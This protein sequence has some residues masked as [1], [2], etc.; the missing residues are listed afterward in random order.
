LTGVFLALHF[1]RFQELAEKQQEGK[2]LS[3]A[4]TSFLLAA[5]LLL[6][7]ATDGLSQQF[8][9]GI[10]G[11]VSDANGVVPGV[12]VTVINEA[13]TVPRETVSNA[14]GEYNFPALPPATYSIR[15]T[16]PGYKTF[17]R[18]GIRIA[19]QQFVT[20]DLTLEVGAVEESI[21][22]TADS[23]LIETSNASQGGVLDRRALEDL[24]S[25]GRNAFMIGVTVP[26]VLHV[27]EPRFNRQQDQMVASQL[28]LGGGG[29]QANNYTLDGVPISDMRGFPVLNPTIEAIEDVKVQVHTFDAEMGRTGGGVFNTTAKSGAN[30][31]HGT[32]FYQYR[33]TWG[34]ELE[35]F[36]KQ[37]GETKQTS[38]LA[39]SFYH[40]YGG[41]VG[42]PIV[43]NRTF[44]WAASEGYRDQVIQGLSRTWPSARQRSGDFS[45]T[46]L[47]GA[48]VR[49]FNPY[50]RDGVANAKCPATGTG[51]LATGGEFLNAVIPQSHPAANPVAFKMASY[52]PAPLSA[53]ENSLANVNKTINLPDFA[54]MFTIKGE[55]KFTN[56]SSLSGVFIY[57]QTKEHG[58]GA[59]PDDISFM[60]QAANWLIRHPKVFV[61]NN[62]NVLSDTMVASFRYGFTVF[63][64]GRNCRG[65]SV[66]QGCFANGIASLGFN[67]S[68]VNALDATAENL[69]PSV[70]FQNFSA[71]GQNLNTAPIEWKS[72]VTLNAALSKLI[73]T[74]TV[75]VGGDYRRMQLT[76]TLL[77]NTAGSFT[78]QNLFSAG[79]GRVGGY[80]FASFLIGAPT[81]GS[82]D[83]NRGGGVYSIKYGGAYVQ[84]D[85]RL[86]HKFTLNYG[87]RFEHESGLRERDDNITVGFDPNATSPE[88]QAIE[89][90]IRRN[91][92]TGPA[93]KGGVMFAGVNGANDYQGD[94]PGVKISPR[95][96]STW[97][98][99]PNTVVRG[100]YGLFFAPW[101]YT[102]QS[103]GTIGFVRTT[104]MAQSAPESA[105]P[106]VTLDNPFPSGLIRPTGSALGILTGVGGNIDFI[107]QNKGAPRVHQ[108]AVDMQRQ[109]PGEVALSIG[110]MGSTGHDI[111]YGGFTNTG[112]EINQ[113][114]PAT[115]PKDAAGRWDAAALRR[116]VPNPFFGV[117]GTG[118]L[119]ASPTILAGQLLRPFPQFNNITKFQ[120][121]EGGRRQ[122]HALIFKLEKRT[123][124]VWGG[125]FN[126]TWS[127]MMDNQWGQFSTF[128]SGLPAPAGGGTGG[129]PQNYYDLD[130]E[131]SVS[132]IDIPHRVVL[133]PI[134]R[135]P[136]PAKGSIAYWFLGGWTASAVVEF[137][138]GPPISAYVTNLSAANLGLFNGLQRPNLT[139]Q[140]VQTTGDDLDRIASADHPS[141]A[142]ISAAGY[143]N[144]GL[145]AYGNAPRTDGNNRYEF[146]QN[147]D[148][149]FTKAFDVGRGQTGEVRFEILNLTN[150]PKFGGANTDISSSAFGLITTS[151]G[152]SRILQLSFRYKF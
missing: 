108:Y 52:W 37:R 33:P 104:T 17:E 36:A 134:I 23:P 84:D 68:F 119:G 79:P 144:P 147:T 148:A 22:V 106:I 57:N 145:G 7:A 129:V 135:I 111:G 10:R 77:N 92:Y 49:I 99:N 152:F 118:E 19:T 11:T 83:F 90:A 88:L 149:V 73:G 8:T 5:G 110:Y 101:Q 86:S 39:K 140:P 58:G 27:G 123:T 43:K 82:V 65:G 44:F 40:L 20:L 46:T 18:H 38:G 53:N 15:A 139:S 75:K 48:P 35:Y 70:S 115:L 50:C 32:A 127:R 2:K 9:G 14:V 150:T 98:L 132:T 151:R 141:A 41:G 3:K 100:G 81:S 120:T 124:R 42:G 30:A 69:F 133:A 51:S 94:P 34:S 128:G 26:T 63:P 95:V 138:S 45:T 142:W 67:P 16:I 78:F 55:H 25:P 93:L 21:T 96:G 137:A 31:F 112:I 76:T 102:Q 89:A 62:T 66:G 59:V 116:S 114:D 117:P 105:V 109:L 24:P 74:H 12:S 72:P 13:T 131:Y 64:D 126:Y 125:Q 4:T 121:T 136:G 6:G 61:L 80:D 103:H 1:P 28:T 47:N 107:D 71:A 122:Y 97:A 146:R 130:A 113:I 143:T 56:S 60:E 91:G 85:W 87:L 29:V 54:D